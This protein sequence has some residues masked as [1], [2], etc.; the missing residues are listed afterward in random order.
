MTLITPLVTLMSIEDSYIY[1]GD[2]N[3]FYDLDDLDEIDD[4]DDFGN[5]NE[6]YVFDDLLC[7]KKD[8]TRKNYINGSFIMKE[9]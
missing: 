8:V 5:L 9:L 4:F 2:F 6:F 3:Y 7:L 1:S